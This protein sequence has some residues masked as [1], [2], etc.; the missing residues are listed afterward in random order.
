MRVIW[1]V[2]YVL[3]FF[4]T[5][6]PFHGWRA[7][8]LRCFGAKIGKGA[9]I[10]PR[11]RIWAPWNLTVGELTGIA[12][13]VTLYSQGRITIGSKTVI[14]QGSYLCA[15]THDYR[16]EGFPLITRPIDIGN[17]CWLAAE[18]FVHPGIRILDGTVV[19][20]RSVVTTDLPGWMVCA[21]HP[22]GPVKER[23][24]VA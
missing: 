15:G 11:V 22:C 1:G 14:S 23:K 24:L 3:F 7:F 5:P 8:L 19:G 12:N 16:R 17:S 4:P 13:G 21:G 2:V 18:V 9:H 20:A 10:Y 6:N